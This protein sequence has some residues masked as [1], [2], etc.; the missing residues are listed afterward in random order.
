MYLNLCSLTVFSVIVEVSV[1]AFMKMIL[2]FFILISLGALGLFFYMIPGPSILTLPTPTKILAPAPTAP[3]TTYASSLLFFD[4]NALRHHVKN[5]GLTATVTLLDQLSSHYGNCHQ[6]AHKA[7][8]FAYELFSNEVFREHAT[9]CHSGGIHGATE[10][11][12]RDHGTN[13]LSVTLSTICNEQLPLYSSVECFHAV[14]HGLMAWS[15]YQLHQSLEYCDLLSSQPNAELCYS[16]VFM[17]NVLGSLSKNDDHYTEYLNSD[18]HFPCTIVAGKY[19]KSCYYYQPARMIVL[20]GQNY[21]RIAAE[22]ASLDTPYQLTCYQGIGKEVPWLNPHQPKKIITACTHAPSG[23]YRTACLQ[24]AIKTIFSGNLTN[25]QEA[26]NFCHLLPASSEGHSCIT[27]VDHW[28]NLIRDAQGKVSASGNSIPISSLPPFTPSKPPFAQGKN[29]QIV[30]NMLDEGYSPQSLSISQGDTI[31]FI[32]KSNSDRWPATNIHPTHRVY[33]LSDINLCGT[34]REQNMFDAC[35]S[36]PPMQ[37]YSFTF[38]EKGIWHY[39]DHLNSS[40]HG[41]ITVE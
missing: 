39:H 3:V 9:F 10:A 14:G 35:R 2:R 6:T 32:N 24:E 12:F 33:P 41:R 40:I 18:L 20:L 26:R 34:D 29:K 7:G 11:F 21:N 1:L 27:F 16:G 15:N 31:L 38:K 23:E 5:S 4:D 13:N 37:S 17:E 19:R 8:R 28:V 30:I 22:C 25:E 36:I